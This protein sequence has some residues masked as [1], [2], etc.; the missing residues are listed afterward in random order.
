MNHFSNIIALL[1]G[2]TNKYHPLAFSAKTNANP[3]ILSHHDTM[4]SNNKEKFMMAM[5]E[6]I[7]CLIKI[8]MFEVVPCSIVPN[9]QQLLHV[10]WRHRR[11]KQQATFTV[12][13]PVTA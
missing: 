2:E 1:N 11:K 10:I 5:E 9:N 12:T 8:D 4:K 3:N 7:Q 13:A 6:E